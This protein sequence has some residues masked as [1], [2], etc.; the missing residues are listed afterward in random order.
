MHRS[1]HVF[2]AICLAAA[3]IFLLTVAVLTIASWF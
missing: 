1:T 2:G 3:G